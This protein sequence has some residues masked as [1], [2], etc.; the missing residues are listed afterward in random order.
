MSWS[1]RE[2]SNN[3]GE[4][5]AQ[6]REVEAEM[7]RSGWILDVLSVEQIGKHACPSAKDL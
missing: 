1:N 5:W 2:A 4:I 7:E 3:P 6:I